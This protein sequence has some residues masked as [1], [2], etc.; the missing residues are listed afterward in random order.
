MFVYLGYVFTIFI[1]Y[2]IWL[3]FPR[4]TEPLY[5]K[6]ASKIGESW[7]LITGC[8]D[9]IGMAMALYLAGKKWNLVLVGRNKDKL[10]S[11][12]N[13]IKS[14][15]VKTCIVQL[16]YSKD[17]TFGPNGQI[18]SC[19]Q[20]IELALDKISHLNLLIN[21]AG[22]SH[23]YPMEFGK[24]SLENMKK[25]VNVNIMGAL[26]TTK[27]ALSKLKGGCVINMGSFSGLCPS[28]LLGVY[29]GTKVFLQ[30][31]GD[32]LALEEHLDVINLDT[33][34][35]STKMSRMK[36][37]FFCPTSNDFAKSVLDGKLS[38]KTA[39]SYTGYFSHSILKWGIVNLM[40]TEFWINYI[41]KLHLNIQ[42]KAL[43]KKQ[44]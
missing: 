6:Y 1:F 28:P 22:I 2:K 29:S 12:D 14:F 30:Y 36:P 18:D 23:E 17:I 20:E 27:I 13:E 9:G 34:F 16:D 11:L 26:S 3:L 32:C 43:R 7:C 8:T 44:K 25:M 15:G 35:V 40:T 39:N 37:N 38:C 5:I 21:N 41:Y 19:H 10:E 31:F 33:Y 42:K 4:H 24:E